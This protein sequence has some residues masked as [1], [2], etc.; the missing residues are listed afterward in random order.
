MKARAIKE[1]LGFAALSHRKLNLARTSQPYPGI[2][3]AI[4]N[5]PHFSGFTGVVQFKHCHGM[6]A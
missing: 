6:L 3:C 1:T 2:A 4:S 5:H